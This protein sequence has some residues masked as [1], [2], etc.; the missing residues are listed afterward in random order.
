M[1]P[2]IKGRETQGQTSLHP[3][4]FRTIMVSQTLGKLY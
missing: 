2:K 1:N 3:A 4:F